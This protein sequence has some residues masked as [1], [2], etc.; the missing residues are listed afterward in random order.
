MLSRAPVASAAVARPAATVET[1][2]FGIGGVLLDRNPRYLYEQLIHDPGALDRFL[3]EVCHPRL[4]RDLRAGVPLLLLTNMPADVFEERR[5][6]CGD[7][8]ALEAFVERVVP[9]HGS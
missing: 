6:R 3:G 9:A 2:A 5:R 8:G 7:A 1:V 4:E